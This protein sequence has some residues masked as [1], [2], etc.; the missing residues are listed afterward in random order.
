M[1]TTESWPFWQARRRAEEPSGLLQLTLKV[2]LFLKIPSTSPALP[3]QAAL[4]NVSSVVTR[5]VKKKK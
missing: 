5:K 1:E 2:G 4:Q 3:S